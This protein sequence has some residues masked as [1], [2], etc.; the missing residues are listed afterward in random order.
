MAKCIDCRE[1]EMLTQLR[2]I[3]EKGSQKS[4]PLSGNLKVS[5]SY[6]VNNKGRSFQAEEMCKNMEVGLLWFGWRMAAQCAQR[7]WCLR[8]DMGE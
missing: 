5:K 3:T 6:H 7:V 1:E 4:K 2:S 8:R